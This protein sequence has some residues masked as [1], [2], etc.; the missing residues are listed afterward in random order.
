MSKSKAPF[1]VGD[2]VRVIQNSFGAKPDL[3]GLEVEVVDLVEV[4]HEDRWIV[5]IVYYPSPLQW[6]FAP[7][8]LVLARTVGAPESHVDET[9]SVP[10]GTPTDDD[11]PADEE[12]WQELGWLPS[13][14]DA[15]NDTDDP[16]VIIPL[17]PG[18]KL[19]MGVSE[20]RVVD[21]DTGGA[22]GKKDA[23]YALIPT[24]P[25]EQVAKVYGFG[26]EKY[27][28]FNWAK[29]YDW[30]LSYSALFRHIEAHRSGDSSDDESGLNHLAH[31]AFHLFTLME[32]ERLGLGKDTRWKG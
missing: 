2:I 27:S 32:F 23:E 12:V 15:H 6:W 5:G 24:N 3:L 17:G 8:D 4:P 31:A 21:P 10:E 30:N 28:A 13:G 14:E 1:K 29:G 20:E 18:G 9:E 7:T 26:A 22:K 16:E 19:L 11:I 25:L